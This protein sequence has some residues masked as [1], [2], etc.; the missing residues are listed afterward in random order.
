MF[1]LERVRDEKPIACTCGAQSHAYAGS[2]VWS[3][4]TP[5]TGYTYTGLYACTCAWRW[6]MHDNPG[7]AD[8]PDISTQPWNTTRLDAMDG[9][10][11]R[12]TPAFCGQQNRRIQLSPRGMSRLDHRSVVGVLF[13]PPGPCLA[14]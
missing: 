9:I 4:L 14:L 10:T 8:R 3:L 6:R 12:P 11:P 1:A 2:S 7:P 13:V 5:S